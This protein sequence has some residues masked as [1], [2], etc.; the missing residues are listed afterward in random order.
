MP[1]TQADLT[2]EVIPEL[3]RNPLTIAGYGSLQKDNQTAKALDEKL[4]TNPVGRLAESIS[5]IVARLADAD[6]KKLTAPPS[7]FGGITGQ[8][9]E[10]RVRYEVAR[11]DLDGVVEDAQAVAQEVRDALALMELVMATH[12]EDAAELQMHI[13]AGRAFLASNL[14]AGEPAA[15]GTEFDRPRERFARRLANLATLHSS[16]ALSVIQMRLTKAA[17]VDM[18]DRFTE[19][20]DVLMPVWRDHAT[21]LTNTKNMSPARVAEATKAHEAL[22]RGLA[23][24]LQQTTGTI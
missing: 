17:A 11:R 12:D 15:G 10:T 21:N 3:F 20:V 6:P 2:Q 24:S 19:T 23:Q 13:D 14:D 4:Q 18:L 22:V 9:L 8:A 7:W 16:Q 5:A 1:V